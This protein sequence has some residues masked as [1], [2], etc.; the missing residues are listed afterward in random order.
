MGWNKSLTKLF[1]FRSEEELHKDNGKHL[2][3]V[4]DEFLMPK[5][6]ESASALSAQWRYSCNGLSANILGMACA[7][8]VKG[9]KGEKLRN[10]GSPS[11]VHEYSQMFYLRALLQRG[12]H[13]DRPDLVAC[14][15]AIHDVGEEY[16]KTTNDIRQYLT[17]YIN[18]YGDSINPGM[19]SSLQQDI[20]TIVKSYFAISREI[21]GEKPKMKKVDYIEGV[22]HDEIASI[23]KVLD[24]IHNISTPSAKGAGR[25]IDET[26]SLFMSAQYP[27]DKCED[28]CDYFEAAALLYPH[29]EELFKHLKRVVGTALNLRIAHRDNKNSLER[30]GELTIEDTDRMI[31]KSLRKTELPHVLRPLRVLKHRLDEQI[32]AARLEAV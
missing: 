13:I 2:I 28:N 31:V 8:L 9:L 25:K 5:T 7:D 14:V 11:I 17:D 6:Q 12:F 19:R 4:V 22:V 10:D 3:R 20:E 23:V 21:E 16:G 1:A 24:R 30:K 29:H 18:K 32:E 15:A 26:G 27:I